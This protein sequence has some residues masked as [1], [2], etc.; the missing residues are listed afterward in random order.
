M[1]VQNSTLSWIAGQ[2][3]AMESL[4][5]ELCDINSG[6]E[7]LAG[8]ANVSA[9]LQPRLSRLGGEIRRIGLADRATVNSCGQLEQSPLAPAISVRKRP[10]APLRVFLGIH[11]DTVYGPESAF[12]K[13]IASGA[14][15]WVG[16]GVVDAKGGLVVLLAALEAFE[17]SDAADRIGWEIL[18]NPDEEIGSPGSGP[19]F[20]QAAKRNHF[21][22][23]F[24]PA[25]PDGNLVSSRKGSWNYALV[26]RGVS[27]HVGR[28]IS[29]GRN[30]IH[31]LAR[32]ITAIAAMQ[33]LDRGVTVNVGRIEGGGPTNVVPDLAICRFNVRCNDLPEHARV[34][35]QL[36]GLVAGTNANGIAAELHGTASCPPKPIDDATARLFDTVSL[37]GKDL[38]LHLTWRPTGGVCDGNRLAAAGLPTI[39]TMGPRGGNLHSDS[40]YIILESLMERASLCA[41][42][43]LHFAQSKDSSP[44]AWASCPC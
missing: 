30:A 41:M 39:D 7:N 32:C 16:P 35:A 8:L 20:A 1:S 12:Q 11:I 21:G 29:A 34:A 36:R 37:C 10:D 40:E 15:R 14:D 33:D 18:L 17:R 22:L 13:V 3:S 26:V 38:G 2:Q 6:S 27:A 43:L 19:L 28:D 31:A 9:A 5:R 42:V 24:E 4:L 23:L 44:V 25:L